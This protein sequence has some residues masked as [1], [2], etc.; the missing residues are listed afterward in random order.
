MV[1]EWFKKNMKIFK[2]IYIIAML[3]YSTYSLVMAVKA[4]TKFREITGDF[5][6]LM[7]NWNGEMITD[8]KA[9][10][11]AENCPTNFN[12]MLHYEWPGTVDGCD[13][14]SI[15]NTKISGTNYTLEKKFYRD[16]CNSTQI[17]NGC[18]NVPE[19]PARTLSIY[20]DKKICVQ[21][22]KGQ[23]F[24][25]LADK[26]KTDGTCV[27][28]YIKCGGSKDS[29]LAVCVP[30][31][32][33]NGS[34]PVMKFSSSST[35]GSTKVDQTNYYQLKSGDVEYSALSEVYLNEEG[36]CRSSPTSTT[37]KG[38]NHPLMTS[39]VSRCD[40]FISTFQPLDG[41]LDRVTLF[42]QNNINLNAVPSLNQ[43]VLSSQRT[44]VFMRGFIGL[45]PACRP[46]A[47]K[48]SSNEGAINSIRAAQTA[49][50]VVAVIVAFI[51]GLVFSCI[52]IYL[53][54]QTEEKNDELEKCLG[55]RQYINWGVK[56]LHIAFL[57]WAVTVSGRIKDYFRDVSQKNC[58]DESTNQN[59]LALSDQVDNYVYSSN[60]KSLIVT[61][62]MVLIDLAMFFFNKMR[63]GS[64][65]ES[66]PDDKAGYR[67][68]EHN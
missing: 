15:T 53:L 12:P 38:G 45:K 32:A 46:E 19:T 66:K 8:I 11:P 42:K 50:L 10:G 36:I 34:C 28:G 39:D 60:F 18:G 49:L 41:G 24:V 33:A 58:G 63:K 3:G 29:M 14:R 57:I 59:L 68:L 65:T 25:E 56:A 9:V 31:S 13:C 22:L 2:I 37:T 51:I 61:G 5:N 30:K 26:M 40:E 47:K 7:V 44:N 67:E 55:V 35:D 1:L 64:T 23:S 4:Y 16:S 48:L 43:Y 21:K 54:C 6:N 62:I 20:N 27:D 17:G 52:E